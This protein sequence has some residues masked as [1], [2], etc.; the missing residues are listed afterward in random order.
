MAILLTACDAHGVATAGDSWTYQSDEL[1]NVDQ[2]K[3]FSL[4]GTF[5]VGTAGREYVHDFERYD[6]RLLLERRDLAAANDA[7]AGRYQ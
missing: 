2:V 6:F 4:F 1:E 5:L 7:L 3:V